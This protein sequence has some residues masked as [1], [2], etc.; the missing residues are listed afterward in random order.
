MNTRR[1]GSYAE[2]LAVAYLLQQGFEI[3]ER[4]YNTRFGEVDIVGRHADVLVF[5]EVKSRRT[6]A[7]EDLEYLMSPTK[8][9]RI[10]RCAKTY[11]S[12]SS[13]PVQWARAVRFDVLFVHLAGKSV[14]HFPA[15]FDE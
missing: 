1:L 12:D 10:I 2:G 11:L 8:R 5:A 15:A 14:R 4:N 13:R 3:L 6:E 9:R 7:V